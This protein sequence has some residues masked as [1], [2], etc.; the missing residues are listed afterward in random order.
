MDLLETENFG[1]KLATE[2]EGIKVFD[3][4]L[5]FSELESDYLDLL[6]LSSSGHVVCSN[7]KDDTF[8]GTIIHKMFQVV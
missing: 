7:T 1:Y 5:D 6:D 3:D 4:A 8:C 2:E